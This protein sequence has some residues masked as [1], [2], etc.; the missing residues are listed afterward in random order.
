M[1]FPPTL[2]GGERI[3][4]LDDDGDASDVIIGREKLEAIEYVATSKV[5]IG[6]LDDVWRRIRVA[7]SGQ[8][9]TPSLSGRLMVAQR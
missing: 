4:F 5:F 3:A 7:A 8:V 2:T 1:E 6:G 9:S